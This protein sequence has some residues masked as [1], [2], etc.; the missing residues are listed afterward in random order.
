MNSS[1]HNDQW[2]FFDN[3]GIHFPQLIVTRIPKIKL[4]Q[5]ESINNI[6]NLM[7]IRDKIISLTNLIIIILKENRT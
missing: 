7:E 1:I 3:Y 4:K 5:L 2:E 6:D